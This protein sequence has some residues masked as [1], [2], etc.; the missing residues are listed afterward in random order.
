MVRPFER[1]AQRAQCRDISAD[2]VRAR[3]SDTPAY[4]REHV[5]RATGMGL[6]KGVH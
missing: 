4:L 5:L 6:R 1:A 2:Q 3:P